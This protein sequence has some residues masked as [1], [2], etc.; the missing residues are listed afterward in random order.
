MPMPQSRV[1]S[2]V[3]GLQGP[4]GPGVPTSTSV[5]GRFGSSTWGRSCSRCEKRSSPV[6]RGSFRDPRSPSLLSGIL[7]LP[8]SHGTECRVPPVRESRAPAS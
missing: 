5:L 2:S 6:L 1:S 7:S 4:S 3:L 8:R